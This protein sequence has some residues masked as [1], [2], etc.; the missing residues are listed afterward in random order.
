MGMSNMQVQQPMQQGSG[1]G[2]AGNKS[3]SGSPPMES[4]AQDTQY[5]DPNP[6]VSQTTMQNIYGSNRSQQ[7]RFGRP[8]QYS[9][10]IQ[11]WD[12]ASIQPQ[13]GIGKG[14]KG[15]GYPTAPT[16]F[17]YNPNQTRNVTTNAAANPTANA[18]TGVVDANHSSY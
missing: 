17:Q 1:K 10:T 2:F 4:V 8:N 18:T 13:Q 3:A 15:G 14:G 11:P 5:I 6:D 9:N 12:N 7:P 16:N